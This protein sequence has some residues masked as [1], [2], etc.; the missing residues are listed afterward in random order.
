MNETTGTNHEMM[1][2]DLQKLLLAYLQKWWLIVLCAVLVGAGMLLYTIRYV[3]PLYRASVT[4]YVNNTRADYQ[5]DSVSSS[6]LSTAQRLVKTYTNIIESDT[7]LEKVAEEGNLNCSAAYL[8]SIMSAA[9]KD[10]TEIFQVF[11]THSDP[12]KAAMIANTIADVAPGQI[13]EFV[14]GS[15][16]KI[17]DY[18][19]VPT[20]RYSPNYEKSAA[21]G[22]VVGA[23]IA[24]IYVTIRFLLD[25][26]LRTPEDLEQIFEFPVL[27]QIPMFSAPDAK[28]HGYGY[29]KNAYE[30]RTPTTPDR[31]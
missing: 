15:S 14:E 19:K 23:V 4:I 29:Q 3:T 31:E 5:A 25:V 22:A 13:E 9:Q 17:I 6:N 27:G 21:L 24:V 30:T 16:T 26:R 12:E 10:G 18:A 28:K 11:I 7:V 2:I 8:R 1:E 20:S